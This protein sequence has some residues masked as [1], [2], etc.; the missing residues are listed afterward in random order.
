[1]RVVAAP[2]D[3]SARSTA[4]HARRR[5]VRRRQRTDRE[6]SGRPRHIEVQ[7]FG[8]STATCSSFRAR[9]LDPAPASEGRR[10]GAGAGWTPAA[11][12]WARRRLPR[13]ARST[14]RRRY[15]RVHSRAETTF[16]F[17]EMNTRLQ[18]EHPVTEAVTGLD[19]VE[20]AAR[21]RR[22]AAYRC[23][24]RTRAA[25]PRDRGA[26]LRRGPGAWISAGDRH[27][28]TAC[29]SRPRG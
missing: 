22:R 3:S 1:M 29:A 11:R 7:V 27:A 14:T 10:G 6:I 28:R 4:R 26:A 15:G 17:L 25:R 24:S 2:A 18:V 9:L 16:Y 12:R 21:R 5:R 20:A 8:D 13:R 19:L 23:A